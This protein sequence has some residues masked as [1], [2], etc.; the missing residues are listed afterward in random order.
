MKILILGSGSREHALAKKMKTDGHE[1]FC[2]PGNLGTDAVCG[3][4]PIFEFPLSIDNFDSVKE[5][6]NRLNIT[7][8]IVSC[9]FLIASGIVDYLEQEGCQISGVNQ[10]AARLEYDR[11]YGKQFMVKHKIPTARFQVCTDFESALQ[12]AQTFI[13]MMGSAVLKANTLDEMRRVLICHNMEQAEEYLREIILDK[14][15]TVIVEERLSGPELSIQMFCDGIRIITMPSVQVYKHLFNNDEGV[16]TSGM[17]A[18]AP[19]P[20]ITFAM[21]VQIHD[22]IIDPISNGIINDEIDLRGMFSVDLILTEEGPRVL[23]FNCHMGDPEAQAVLPLLESDLSATLIAC[24]EG[25]LE[26][27]MPF[28]NTECTCSIVLRRRAEENSPCE[29]VI[30]G[31]NPSKY[32]SEVFYYLSDVDLNPAGETIIFGDNV[33]TVT[34]Q[35]SHLS[36]AIPKAYEMAQGPSFPG[37]YYRTDIGQKAIEASQHKVGSI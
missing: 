10:E 33:L 1:V 5:M 24:I 17:G 29:P 8:T 2:F 34:A 16:V 25:N 13:R 19:S 31:L 22:A 11:A 28:W 35:G 14:K 4:L 3:A 12:T 7:L 15:E 27:G 23:E 37:R 30:K 32:Q 36:Y 9:P 20:L 26:L 18:I 6:I 21:A